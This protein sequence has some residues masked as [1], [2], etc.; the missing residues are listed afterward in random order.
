M[1]FVL[2][3]EEAVDVDVVALGRKDRAPNARVNEGVE[4]IVVLG[5]V[6]M[7]V[8]NRRTVE[9]ALCN[10]QLRHSDSFTSTVEN[11]T[12]GLKR[13]AVLKASCQRCI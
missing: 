3:S 6:E 2:S 10:G 9:K 11:P 8:D 7:G 12:C 13:G 4:G 1:V 5:A